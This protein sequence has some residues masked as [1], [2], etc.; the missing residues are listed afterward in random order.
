MVFRPG[1]YC[2]DNV[3]IME[4]LDM[5]YPAMENASGRQQNF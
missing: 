5:S 3:D 1:T 4:I 2:I